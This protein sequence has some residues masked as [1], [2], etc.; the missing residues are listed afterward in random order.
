MLASL[1]H[2]EKTLRFD[3]D[4]NCLVCLAC[5]HGSVVNP[6]NMQLH[7]RKTHSRELTKEEQAKL[8]LVMSAAVSVKVLSEHL[9]K[10]RYWRP[11]AGL[12]ITDGWLCTGENH[13][14]KYASGK[15]A[16]MGWHRSVAKHQEPCIP[17]KV[18]Q[19]QPNNNSKIIAVTMPAA[20]KYGE[21]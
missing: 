13:T 19:L 7:L 1:V 17:A 6:A 8:N 2:I 10:Q 21:K 5:E 14:C 18:Q 20:G 4:Y 15:L 3:S 16:T 9:G 11:I 12:S